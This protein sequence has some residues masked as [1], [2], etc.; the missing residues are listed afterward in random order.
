MDGNRFTYSIE[1]GQS[2]LNQMGKMTKLQKLG[3]A[4]SVYCAQIS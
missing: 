2:I 4:S 3:R 1:V